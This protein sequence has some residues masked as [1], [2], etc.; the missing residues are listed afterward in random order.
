MALENRTR[1]SGNRIMAFGNCIMAPV[2]RIMA[3]EN[4]IMAPGNC[5]MAVENRMMA[6]WNQR[7]GERRAARRVGDARLMGKSYGT[8]S[9][10]LERTPFFRRFSPFWP[11]PGTACFWL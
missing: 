4:R 8:A 2:N 1:A 11:R 5:I 7:A 9:P 6:F 3:V 10:A